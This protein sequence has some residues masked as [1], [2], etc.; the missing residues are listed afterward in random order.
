MFNRIRAAF[1]YYRQE[2]KERKRRA[3]VLRNIRSGRF[4]E[5]L[6][7][8]RQQHRY[9]RSHPLYE[10]HRIGTDYKC[11]IQVTSIR[12]IDGKYTSGGSV[13]TKEGVLQ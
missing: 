6:D 3:H 13:F 7:D 5:I 10:V 1:R 12:K 9:G 4:I 11:N 8:L 2:R